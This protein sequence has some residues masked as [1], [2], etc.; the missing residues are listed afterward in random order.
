M[1]EQDWSRSADDI[2][3]INRIGQALVGQR[4]L[5][6]L[7]QFVTDQATSLTG[8]QFGAFFSS[9][10]TEQGETYIL[11]ALAGAPRSA[12]EKL[13]VGTTV[14]TSIVRLDDVKKDP[15]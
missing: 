1:V 4:D 3:I 13:T 6:A 14:C 11:S 12:F 5:Q 15:R 2:E 10:I 9:V 8:A 7:V